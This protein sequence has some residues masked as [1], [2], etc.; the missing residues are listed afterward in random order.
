MIRSRYRRITFFFARIL[1]GLIFWEWILPRIGLRGWS[2]RN[3]S[4][5]LKSIAVQFRQLAISLGGVMI[6]VGQFLSTRVDV[7]PEE[8]TEELSDLQDAVPPEDFDAIRQVAES[9]FGKPLSETYVEFDPVPVAAAS[10]GQVHSA[11][12]RSDG[13]EGENQLASAPLEAEKSTG[14]AVEESSLL[15]VVVKVQ[16]PEIE[17]IIATDLSA[18]RTVGNWL[19]HYPPIRRR[20]D[21]PAL[22]D[23]FTRTLYEE[24]DYI[25]EG[26]NAET[27]AENFKDQPGVK[28]P[29]V[30]WAYTT[31]RVL[32]LEDVQAI[33]VTDYT[34]IDNAG[35]DRKEVAKRLINTYLKQIFEDGFFHADPHPGNLF[36]EPISQKQTPG[37]QPEGA[38]PWRLTFIDF[39]MVGHVQPK[40]RQGMRE[41]V[42][43]VGMRDSAR[44]V[45]A[46]QE[47][48]MLLPNADLALL[49]KAGTEVFNKFWGMNMSEMQHISLDDAHNLIFQF[50]QLLY[51]MPFQLPEDLIFL[52]RAVSILS[53]MATGLD[54]EFNV[55]EA[56]SPFATKLISEETTEGRS[57]WIEVILQQLKRA[58]EIP[59]RV[60]SV[61]VKME[62]GQLEVR[63][64]DVSE[65]I[66]NVD[67]AIRRLTTS[68]IFAV[69]LISAVQLTLSNKTLLAG[70]LYGGALI[71]FIW[72]LSGR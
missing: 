40:M 44:I 23:E 11:L 69:M 13:F 71:A 52:G 46:Y 20:A 9:E 5:R 17:T 56:I 30:A 63:S 14:S 36:V 55:W 10:L 68:L 26:H 48:G 61:L 4:R 12:I 51:T 25:A 38:A 31:K 19:R 37:E 15:H 50:R 18:L 54:P 62:R 64:P 42:I 34:A 7:M 8:I 45:K 28:V 66:R 43:G 29:R 58:I 67:V 2:R 3:R 27:F 59:Q 1:I 70:V 65:H 41:L 6:K 21:V 24:I 49:E 16:R 22:L 33:K 53:G 39:G 60:E 35:I 72:L 57:T 47:L 32:T